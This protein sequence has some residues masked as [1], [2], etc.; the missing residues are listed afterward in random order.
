MD[1]DLE[2][3]E[4]V[5]LA[6]GQ[7]FLTWLWFASEHNN[8]LFRTADG[9][10]F[11][12]AVEQ[13]VAVQG[14]EGEAKETAVCSGPMAELREARAGLRT[15]KKV[16]KVKVR[17]ERDDVHWQ[18]FLDASTLSIQGLKTPKVDMRLDEGEDPDARILE[19]IY[20]IEKCTAYI[21]TV[22]AAFLDLRFG[23]RWAEEAEYM[24][25]W[26]LAQPKE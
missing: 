22:F 6:L 3:A 5:S 18:V 25:A 16:H 4:S 17:I 20:L 15:G 11:T 19:K 2:R 7:E 14:G 23:S 24:R 12:V 13:K 1:L 8:G 10:A 21:D 9:E 26:I